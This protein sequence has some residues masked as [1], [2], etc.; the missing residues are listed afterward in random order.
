MSD[1]SQGREFWV[2]NIS[3][4]KESMG[5]RKHLRGPKGPRKRRN[6]SARH[7]LLAPTDGQAGQ[8]L[9]KVPS[10]VVA[11]GDERPNL[12]LLERSFS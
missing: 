7:A 6:T 5:L 2:R 4:F 1:D 3:I 9:G 11:S 8:Q 10:P 12:H